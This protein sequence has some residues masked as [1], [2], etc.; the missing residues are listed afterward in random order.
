[1]PWSLKIFKKRTKKQILGNTLKARIYKKIKN[2]IIPNLKNF[3]D[4]YTK[5]ESHCYDKII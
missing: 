5:D 3:L 2:Y 1:M 4:N